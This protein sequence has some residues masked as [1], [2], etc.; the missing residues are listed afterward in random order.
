[1]LLLLSAKA[2]A[3]F[4]GNVAVEA[5]HFVED[6]QFEDQFDSNVTA[7]FQPQWDGEWNDGDDRWSVELFMR[8]DNRDA[9]RQHADVREA[10]WLS[11][12][13]DNEW[14]VGVSTMFWGVT[15]SKHLVDVIN[16]TD[17]VE[18]IDGEDKLGQ[19]MI[20]LKRYQDWG[21]LDFLVLPGFRERTFHEAE[22][23]L[24][25]PLVVDT[26]QAAYESSAEDR[27]VDYAL[28]FSQTYGDLDLGL[29]WFKGT[30]R[31]PLLLSGADDDGNPVLTPFYEQMTQYGLDAQLIVVDWIWKL[32]A[33]RREA[34][35]NDYNAYTAGFEYTFYGVFDSAV[36][37][38][39]IVEYS[40]DGRPKDEA[41]VLD[42]DVFAG[43]R[44]AFNDVQSSEIL[45]GFFVD[46]DNRSRS[47]RV[48]ANRRF[49]ASWKGTLELQTFTDI[50]P[51]DPLQAL[52]EDDFVRVEMAYYY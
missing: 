31:D 27:H 12:D 10:L 51:D 36:D 41:A 15:E 50:D 23:R 18:N 3:G 34:D 7:S 52:A 42:D 26:D 35:S 38:G 17:A 9:G 49:G 44:L 6:A 46:A 22:G 39:A 4:S 48:E 19:P 40:Y 29:S 37:L 45:A 8:A 43:A 13:D 16:Q 30:S 24:R 21:V 1:M 5:Q 47:F 20:H 25:P 11:I 28:R 33:I 32:E 14:R 2:A